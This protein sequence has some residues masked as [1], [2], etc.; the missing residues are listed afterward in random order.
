[1]VL[2]RHSA[3]T[4]LGLSELSKTFALMSPSRRRERR[5]WRRR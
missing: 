2:Y 4:V 3:G 1:M 5:A